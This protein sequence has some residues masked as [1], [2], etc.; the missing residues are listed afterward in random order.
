[1][2]T[3]TAQSEIWNQRLR[4]ETAIQKRWQEAQCRRVVVGAEHAD[5]S[6][7][8]T[9]RIAPTAPSAPPA[10]SSEM[11]ASRAAVAAR[12]QRAE[13]RQAQ[14]EQALGLFPPRRDRSALQPLE[15]G[16]GCDMP[17]MA[18]DELLVRKHH[19][20][21]SPRHQQ[22]QRQLAASCGGVMPV[23][24]VPMQ[25]MNRQMFAP[26]APATI[27]ALVAAG[28]V[29]GAAMTVSSSTKQRRQQQSRQAAPAKQLAPT[30]TTTT[31]TAHTTANPAST[32]AAASGVHTQLAVASVTMARNGMG[33]LMSYARKPMIRNSFFRSIG[34]PINP[35]LY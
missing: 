12:Q 24:V 35:E 25:T 31:T 7:Q 30:T 3:P 20:I 22:E 33:S 29:S 21:L 23:D 5:L 11:L 16:R 34:G 8:G 26:P 6:S 9:R 13:D 28:L 32:A 2:S 14:A 27:S 15:R 10:P 17:R 18:R 4:K 19:G 1:M